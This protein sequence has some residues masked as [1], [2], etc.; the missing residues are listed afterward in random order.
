[1]A[2]IFS[3][4]NFDAYKYQAGEKPYTSVM[5]RPL[6]RLRLADKQL[7]AAMQF[8]ARSLRLQTTTDT[9]ALMHFNGSAADVVG[10]FEATQA[11]NNGELFGYDGF[12]K[13]AAFVQ[14]A[15]T[16]LLG[17]VSG[18]NPAMT[19]L[20]GWTLTGITA[21]KAEVKVDA[22]GLTISNLNG[23]SIPAGNV[24]AVSGEFSSAPGHPLALSIEFET[25]NNLVAD[26]VNV[27]V[28]VRFSQTSGGAVI[29]TA[30][31]TASPIVWNGRMILENSVVPANGN[32]AKAFVK[33]SYASGSKAQVRVKN[34]M[35]EDS[36]LAHLFSI[37]TK[38]ATSLT[39]ANLVDFSG[40]AVTI[41]GW[42]NLSQS[43]LSEHMSP[44]CPV[45]LVSDDGATF[46]QPEHLHDDAGNLVFNLV[47]TN[48]TTRQATSE[49]V[50]LDGA[51]R[52]TY[53]PFALRMSKTAGVVEFAIVDASF[54]IQKASIPLPSPLPS[55]RWDLR[56]GRGDGRT[57]EFG[58]G[59]TEIRYDTAW[60][61][62][63]ELSLIALSRRP[64]STGIDDEEDSFPNE[65]GVNLIENPCGK[66]GNY[67]WGTFPA[68][69]QA[70]SEDN[71]IG[72]GFVWSGTAAADVSVASELIPIANGQNFH[73]SARMGSAAGTTGTHG[74][75]VTFYASNGTTVVGSPLTVPATPASS[76]TKY[77]L[78]SSG[79]AGASYMRVSMYASSGF[80]S[81]KAFWSKLKLSYGE[82][83]LFSDD[84]TPA[85]AVYA[86]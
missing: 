13:G 71:L 25:P 52:G 2:E 69:F 70:V 1:L 78:S 74:I 30:S 47:R 10:E 42:M 80:T 17:G 24:E 62:D 45:C 15:A 68:N 56:I 18:L 5:N 16:N 50:S 44:I 35:V 53:L 3:Y 20:N 64:F 54:T 23:T 55:G 4:I 19:S 34:F 32:F 81:S 36:K 73:L 84:S 66:Y 33:I 27:E 6:E 61:N 76:A 9:R 59:V 21:Q 63:F 26:S 60:I 57:E 79:I 38:A 82:D 43:L 75:A 39:Y 7:D 67:F 11:G 12:M 48:G 14:P 31:I 86:P 65:Y 51:N 46:I 77:E 58:G 28:G 41:L 40:D 37:G 83:S 49:D 85:F 29:G 22:T 8:L 72:S